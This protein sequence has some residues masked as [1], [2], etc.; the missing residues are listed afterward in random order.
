LS[1]FCALSIL[2]LIDPG[3]LLMLVARYR[4]MLAASLLLSLTAGPALAQNLANDAK[5][6]MVSNMFSKSKDAKAKQAAVQASYFYLGRLTGP[7][8]QIEAAL[9]AQG[10]AVTPQNAGPTMQA[11]ARTVAQRATE[12]QGIGRRLSKTAPQG[13]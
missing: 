5:C 3:G 12:M 6:F 7:T 9:A 4:T 10:R 2:R 11:C 13:R 1:C 8:A